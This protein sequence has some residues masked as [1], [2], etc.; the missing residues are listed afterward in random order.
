ME[1]M[2]RGG[3]RDESQA[4]E[5]LPAHPAIPYIPVKGPERP[6]RPRV[7]SSRSDAAQRSGALTPGRPEH[8]F[9]MDVYTPAEQAAIRDLYRGGMRKAHVDSVAAL[10]ELGNRA[11]R[12][13]IRAVGRAVNAA[14][15]PTR[16]VAFRPARDESSLQTQL[17][18]G[19]RRAEQQESS[20]A[21]PAL[22]VLEQT[23]RPIHAIAAAA[24][25]D[26]Q[27]VKK[28]GIQGLVGHGSL[29]AAGRGF[30][31]KDKSLF[32]DVLQE[33]GVPSLGGA[34]SAAGFLLDVGLDPT[35]YVS[36]GTAP[37]ARRVALK[38]AERQAP[39]AG[40]A[41]VA[42]RR[43]AGSVTVKEA[44]REQT[45]AAGGG[46]VSRSLS[47]RAA[48][49]AERRAPGRG[50]S[51]R[52]AGREVPG[53]T[54]GTAAAGRGVK[55]AAGRVPGAAR[56]GNVLKHFAADVNPGVVPDGLSRAEYEAI[57]QATRTAR[58]TASREVYKAR[59]V[60]RALQKAVGPANYQKVLDAIEAGKVRSL[61]SEL[62]KPAEVMR[63]AF[64]EALKSERRAGVRV[65]ERGN[66]LPHVVARTLEEGGG[67]GVESV[68]RRRVRP[69]S[70]RA[71][72]RQG[73]LAELRVSHPGEYVEDPG[74]LFASRMQDNA[75][76][77]SAAGLNRR[78]ADM[79]RTFKPGMRVGTGEAIYHLYGSD[80]RK[81]NPKT[82]RAE[83][84][85]L[86]ARGLTNRGGRYVVLNH[87]AVDRALK[88]VMP[89]GERSTAG[90]VW[91]R[92]QGAWKFAATQPNPGFHLRNFFGD[93]QNAYLATPGQRLPRNVKDAARVLAHVGREEQA[94]RTLGRVVADKGG[95]FE[96]KRYG[97]VTHA[98][99]A[100]QLERV[101][102]I[103]AGFAAREL[104]DLLEAGK[105]GKVGGR[106]DRL[107]RWVNNREDVFRAA[108]AIEAV[109]RGASWEDAA[110]FAA[111]Y[112]FDYSDL[113]ELERKVLR[114]VMPFY[115]F[116]ARN[117]PLQ[118]QSVI[119]RP[120]KF[121][122]YE[123]VR[124]ELAKA[125]G[126]QDG[127]EQDLP[128]RE[129]RGV[130]FPVVLGGKRVT[131]SLGP[132]GLPITDLN[133]FPVTRNP[134][135][136][137]DEWI[138]RAMSLVTPGIK[139]P[140]ELWSN[141]SFFFRDQ[142]EKEEGPLVPAP[143][144]IVHLI[145]AKQR[146]ELG[147]VPDYVDRR[148]GKL[149]WGAPAKVVYALNVLPGPAG[150]LNRVTTPSERPGQ[151]RGAKAVA[152]LGVRAVPVDVVS[153][154]INLLYD[155]RAKLEKQR[156]ALGQR[157]G[158]VGEAS[159]SG[160][161][162][163]SAKI[164]DVDSHISA[165]RVKRGDVILPGGKRRQA[166]LEPGKPEQWE[167][168]RPEIKSGEKWSI[169]R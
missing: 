147:F 100:K 121:A 118:W 84:G 16:G 38:A 117:I 42:A 55:R 22:K 137:A 134:V 71:R 47:D 23:L 97:R 63:D 132:S 96:T 76:A 26:V 29:N 159:S 156:A 72:Q 53:V 158:D 24:K 31:L 94:L 25:H 85:R 21:A 46:A 109:K 20:T 166:P 141:M 74:V 5:R 149:Q 167:I 101:G 15:G 125:F 112:H 162:Q 7:L 56:A 9:D 102:G 43:P 142:I 75:M 122:Q 91:D 93:M 67:P 92:V 59:Q 19:L 106:A 144:W 119:T 123:K 51:V 8:D 27:Q 11:Q 136:Q 160:Y 39:A 113:T 90:L 131:I 54:R 52:V 35:T 12:A 70:S 34:R 146:R 164:R 79:G 36:G 161:E 138:D 95:G 145:P 64:G 40:R 151:S 78:I 86:G 152:Y 14:N 18:E 4:R 143:E 154:T 58:S 157:A 88:T 120:G 44:R 148:T 127:W 45:R 57:R 169:V 49:L 103:R 116:S 83:L 105:K 3:R 128:E 107:R 30:A 150:F 114:R 28:H 126:Y 165:L 10:Y 13:N 6:R 135:K 48:A 124:E 87:Q 139:T 68:G 32:S 65:A 60:A 98:E 108:T 80:L 130:P 62:R 50:V 82:D 33:A 153:N 163:L 1:E 110:A 17:D 41:A 129:Q 81:L 69:S 73:T 104:H 111:R 37:V 115:T 133:E 66:Y 89:G 99:A 168:V 61:P 155:E 2:R 140:V 77:R